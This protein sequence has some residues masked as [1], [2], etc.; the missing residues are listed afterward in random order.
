M[1][2]QRIMVCLPASQSVVLSRSFVNPFPHNF[3]ENR[4]TSS[5]RTAYHSLPHR[6]ESSLTASLLL[7]L[8]EL[9][10]C[11]DPGVDAMGGMRL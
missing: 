5:S 10:F 4:E 9:R 11:G 8:Q 3:I 6:R 7:S 2:K 1:T